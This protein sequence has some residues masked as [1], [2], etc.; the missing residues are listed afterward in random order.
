M[1]ENISWSSL[2]GMWNCLLEQQEAWTPVPGSWHG[3]SGAKMKWFHCYMLNSVAT[4]QWKHPS[5]TVCFKRHAYWHV[6][7]CTAESYWNILV[8]ALNPSRLCCPATV[9]RSCLQVILQLLDV[10]EKHKVQSVSRIKARLKMPPRTSASNRVMQSGCSMV[11]TA[12]RTEWCSSSRL[13]CSTALDGDLM[14]MKTNLKV[15]CFQEEPKSSFFP[16]TTFTTLCYLLCYSL[17][18]L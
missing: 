15:Y 2:G 17:M 18:L 13:T 14:L 10:Q 9:V 1:D 6:S 8:R 16:P 5:T 7:I 3:R 4:C 12:K 11:N